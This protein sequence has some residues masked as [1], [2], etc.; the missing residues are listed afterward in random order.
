MDAFT[1][2]AKL[3][4][5]RENKPTHGITVG[6][7]VSSPPQLKIQLNEVVLLS[8]S[9]LV[10]SSHLLEERVKKITVS[11]GL[12]TEVIDKEELKVGDEVIL[13]PTADYQTF[14]LIDKVVRL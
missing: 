8:A 9:N 14:Y 4:K 3:L 6:K 12:V 11:N 1:E 10:I 2:L 7:V 13:I 5:E